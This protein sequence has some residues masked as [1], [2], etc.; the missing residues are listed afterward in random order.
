MPFAA[1]GCQTAGS[2]VVASGRVTLSA[3]S[4][5]AVAAM[6]FTPL[7]LG[8]IVNARFDDR[9]P[10]VLISG[11]KSFARGFALPAVD[12]TLKLHVSSFRL[13]SPQSP[14]IMYPEVILLDAAFEVVETA[15]PT[16]FVYRTGSRG[17]G[18]AADVFVDTQTSRAHYVLVT[19]RAPH[20]GEQVTAQTNVTTQLPMMLPRQ[21]GF[22]S[23]FVPTGSSSAALRLLAAPTG[24]VELLAERYQPRRVD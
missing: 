21:G 17:D 1:T 2:E 19:E 9:S 18:L 15:Q 3:A 23:W 20:D 24:R 16:R 6:P 12:G 13:G 22:M 10:A 14:T 7:P 8:E 4:T 5:I 11:R